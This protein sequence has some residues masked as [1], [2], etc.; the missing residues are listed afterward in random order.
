[1]QKPPTGAW[2]A[3]IENICLAG[4]EIEWR[5]PPDYFIAFDG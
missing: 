2:L 5:E 1:L 3:S 4:E